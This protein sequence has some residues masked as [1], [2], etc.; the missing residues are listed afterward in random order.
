MATVDNEATRDGRHPAVQDR[1]ALP[2]LLHNANR[3]APTIPGVEKGYTGQTATTKDS[4][5][6]DKSPATATT[7][8]QLTRNWS[9]HALSASTRRPGRGGIASAG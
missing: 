6:S 7:R 1:A 2:K 8:P 4:S 9:V 3:I 5:T